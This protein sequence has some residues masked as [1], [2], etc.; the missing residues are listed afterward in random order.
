MGTHLF[1]FGSSPP[2]NEQL[3]DTFYRHLST[4]KVAVL[5]IEREG[6][7]AYIPKYLETFPEEV[8]L[9]PLALKQ[10]YTNEEI[11]ELHQCGGIIIGGGDTLAY[12]RF[13][14]ETELNQVI[15][16]LFE[17]GVPVAGFS[18][19]ALISPDT[20]VVSP[21]DNVTEEQLFEKGLGLLPD[22]VLSAHYLEWEEQSCLKQA[23]EKTEVSVGYGIAERS[24]AYFF[25]SRL[26]SIE[27]YVHIEYI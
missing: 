2:F 18:A 13:I 3:S 27:G 4:S 8:S 16:S 24:G 19:G 25:N 21:K 14:V 22:A 20:S 12:R 15:R 17:R 5:Y 7:D 6:S 26:T 23:V 11:K 9:F 1:L 10:H